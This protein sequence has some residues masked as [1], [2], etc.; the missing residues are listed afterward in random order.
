MSQKEQ[1]NQRKEELF[2]LIFDKNKVKW[3]SKLRLLLQVLFE[4]QLRLF[5]LVRFWPQ[6]PLFIEF[7]LTKGRQGIYI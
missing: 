5:L 2:S 1:I 3:R 6:G 4:C 7:L